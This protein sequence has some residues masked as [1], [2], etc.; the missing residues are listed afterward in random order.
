MKIPHLL[1]PA[2]KNFRGPINNWKILPYK[3][4]VI[5]KREKVGDGTENVGKYPFIVIG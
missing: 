1:R 4:Q 3:N 5:D 2:G